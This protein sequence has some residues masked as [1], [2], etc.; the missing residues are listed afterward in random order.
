MA[1]HDFTNDDSPA[2]RAGIQQGDVIVA[3]DGQP[4]EYMAQ[5]QQ[6]VGFKKPGETVEVTVLR[7]TN[8]RRSFKVR[9]AAAPTEQLAGRDDAATPAERVRNQPLEAGLSIAVEPLTQE[10]AAERGITVVRDAGGGL[11]VTDVAPDGPAAGKLLAP[12]PGGTDVILKVDGAP[13]RTRVELRAALR[14]AK[15]GDIVTLLVYSLTDDADRRA[16]RVVRIKLP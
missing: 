8:D 14:K 16:Q 15:S 3:L 5:L 12:S 9:L 6:R 13:V 4:V 10:D 11:V 2:K 7:G 1:V